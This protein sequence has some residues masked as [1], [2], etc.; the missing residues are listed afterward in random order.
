[1]AILRIREK[2]S[3]N[4]AEDMIF[5][6]SLME[7]FDLWCEGFTQLVRDKGKVKPGRYRAFGYQAPSHR[8]ADLKLTWRTLRMSVGSAPEGS[9]PR[10]Q[11]ELDLKPRRHAQAQKG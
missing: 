9:S 7:S 1:M 3:D 8:K 5:D 10:A 4:Q 6:R 2:Y 11:E